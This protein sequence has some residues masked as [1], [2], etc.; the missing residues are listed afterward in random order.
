LSKGHMVTTLLI[1]MVAM[2][3]TAVSYGRM[4]A[5]YPSAGS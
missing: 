1:S 4:A 3:L 5:L 2:S